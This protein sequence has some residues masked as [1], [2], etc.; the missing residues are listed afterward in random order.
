MLFDVSLFQL[1]G[2]IK[3]GGLEI[4]EMKDVPG[5]TPHAKIHLNNAQEKHAHIRDLYKQALTL[6]MDIITTVQ[7]P[8][9]LYK[10]QPKSGTK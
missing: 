9:S 10:S 4:P 3:S 8:V 2:L 6:G 7:H 1:E 5:D